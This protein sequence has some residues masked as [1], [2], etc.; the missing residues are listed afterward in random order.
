MESQSI[1]YGHKK[2]TLHYVVN[3][4]NNHNISGYV[5]VFFGE[6]G[7]VKVYLLIQMRIQGC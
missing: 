6:A 3:K 7:Y 2:T 4:K 5:K 1:K